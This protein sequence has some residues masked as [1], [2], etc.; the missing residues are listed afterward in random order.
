MS[1]SDFKTISQVQTE[2]QIKYDEANF[3]QKVKEEDI[4]K[5][6][7]NEI[8]FNIRTLDVFSS[9]AARCELIILPVLREAY[10]KVSSNFSLWV[11][12]S[13]RYDDN[14][15]GTPDYIVSKRSAL[16][17]TVLE[18]PLLLVA[19]AKKNDFDQGWAQCLAELVAAQK[20][21]NDNKLSVYGIVTDGKY[22]EFGKLTDK[23][24]NKNIDSFVIDDLFELFGA[25]NYIFT[26]AAP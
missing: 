11:Q 16:G 17:K 26:L 21:N 20:L 2:Y 24:F 14:L 15:N 19:E 3:I 8:E 1:F 18:F 10:K 6:F 13:I 5:Q 22:W 7:L 25:L 9:E 12:K 23:L 4:S